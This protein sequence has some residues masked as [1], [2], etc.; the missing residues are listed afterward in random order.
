LFGEAQSRV[1]VTS[2]AAD[3]IKVVERAKL[4]GVAAIQIGTVGG[5]QLTVKT[6]AGEFAWN[7]ADLHDL[8]WN[9]IARIM[10]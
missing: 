9:S 6:A 5:T 1:V 10:K 3:A 2:T 8:W 4:M 7:P